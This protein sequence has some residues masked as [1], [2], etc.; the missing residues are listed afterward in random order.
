LFFG[1][2]HSLTLSF[3]VLI[4]FLLVRPNGIMGKRGFV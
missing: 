4:L 2:E 1:P 3:T